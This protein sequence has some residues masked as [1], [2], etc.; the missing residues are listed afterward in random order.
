MIPICDKLMQEY[1]C[2]TCH[3]SWWVTMLFHNLI[4]KTVKPKTP[5]W[6][7][8]QLVLHLTRCLEMKL[9]LSLQST[10][11]PQVQVTSLSRFIT[12]NNPFIYHLPLNRRQCLGPMTKP[13]SG[14]NKSDTDTPVYTH[15]CNNPQMC[16]Y[17]PLW[18]RYVP[19]EGYFFSLTK[20]FDQNIETVNL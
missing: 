11:G 5:R 20:N 4:I 12:T 1:H 19:E 2:M 16:F 6:S 17:K 13:I 3:V 15:L 8:A 7:W 9:H 18:Q 10:E 14:S